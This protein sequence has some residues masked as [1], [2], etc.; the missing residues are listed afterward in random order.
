M[1]GTLRAAAGFSPP[2]GANVAE[3]SGGGTPSTFDTGEHGHER[4]STI[5]ADLIMLPR[6][7]ASEF[8][9]LDR[10]LK[11]H[12]DELIEEALAELPAFVVERQPRVMFENN[13]ARAR[14]LAHVWAPTRRRLARTPV[15]VVL[16][17]HR[18]LR[19]W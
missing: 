19:G 7:S 15:A 12:E 2:A 6:M 10:I 9:T 18:A 8:E 11:N 13:G 17:P 14:P 5:S 4:G 16:C 1:D 3:A